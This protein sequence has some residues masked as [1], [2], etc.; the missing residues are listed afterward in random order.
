MPMMRRRTL[1]AMIIGNTCDDKYNIY[2]MMMKKEI[3]K[4][5]IEKGR[6]RR[7]IKSG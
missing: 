2:N 3:K 4:R 1:I 6:S 7:K 5:K